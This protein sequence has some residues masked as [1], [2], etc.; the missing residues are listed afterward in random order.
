MI[1]E[2]NASA[3]AVLRRRVHVSSCSRS[4]S[5]STISTVGLPIAASHRQ[6]YGMRDKQMS[7]LFNV[8]VTHDTRAWLYGRI[9]E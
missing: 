4:L 3:C 1:R 5:F 9:I 2:R 6:S 8:F 7:Y